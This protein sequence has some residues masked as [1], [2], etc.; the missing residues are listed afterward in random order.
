MKRGKEVHIYVIYRGKG[1]CI[2]G[3]KRGSKK[4][5]GSS[6]TSRTYTYNVYIE[7]KRKTVGWH[8]A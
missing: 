6:R 2:I 7:V 1:M 3:S 4:G 5:K 8:P